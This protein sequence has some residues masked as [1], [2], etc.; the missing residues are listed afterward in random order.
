MGETVLPDATVEALAHIHDHIQHDMG[1]ETSLFQLQAELTT[2]HLQLRGTEKLM[3]KQEKTILDQA[4]TILSRNAQLKTMEQDLARIQ[5][6]HSMLRGLYE[7]EISR[8]IMSRL[9]GAFRH[10]QT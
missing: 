2:L 1:L 3:E 4:E 6:Q 10:A 5:T 7:H 8:T 9:L